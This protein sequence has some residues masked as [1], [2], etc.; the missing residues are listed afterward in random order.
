LT[1]VAELITGIVGAVALLRLVRNI[2]IRT[3]GRRWDRYERLGRL[4]TNAQVSFFS[5]VLTEPPGIRRSHAA[6][7]MHIGGGGEPVQVPKTWVEYVWIDRSYYVHAVAD[8]DETVHAYS[9][10][11]RQRRFHPKFREYGAVPLSYRFLALLGLREM[12]EP[13]PVVRLG[14]TRFA[15]LSRPQVAASWMWLHN[16]HYYEAHWGGNPGKYQW[17]VYSVNDAGASS[18]EHGAWHDEAAHDL[19]FGYE[20][21]DLIDPQLLLQQAAARADLDDADGP[22]ELDV[23]EDGEALPDLEGLTE[24]QLAEL[25]PDPPPLPA[26]LERFRERA[27]I[28]TWTVIGPGLAFDDYPFAARPNQPYASIFG[29]NI[30]IVRVFDR[31]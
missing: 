24:E 10:T 9:V 12:V 15:A 22:E 29:P 7:V 3:L 21:E 20:N 17:F 6:S 27:R 14:K 8:E 13:P 28:N 18:W 1:R 19:S 11:T 31:T 5:S 25:F 16:W 4:A 30:N 26:E 2:Y 23:D